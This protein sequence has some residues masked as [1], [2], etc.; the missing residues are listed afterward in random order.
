ME[1]ALVR[2]QEGLFDGKV[3]LG[4]AAPPQSTTSKA[5]KQPKQKKQKKEE[6]EKREQAEIEAQE[7]EDDDRE[8]YRKEIGEEPDEEFI[9][10]AVKAKVK[11]EPGIKVQKPKKTVRFPKQPEAK[12]KKGAADASEEVQ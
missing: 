7:A 8:W 12:R 3:M 10:A 4:S 6:E 11:A 9:Q 5:A 1:L 2:V